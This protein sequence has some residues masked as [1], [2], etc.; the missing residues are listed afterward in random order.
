M[1]YFWPSL[2]NFWMLISSTCIYKTAKYIFTATV[3]V[4]LYHWPVAI[5]VISQALYILILIVGVDHSFI[6]VYIYS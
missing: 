4:N 5:C 6:S 1:I 3:S 2:I